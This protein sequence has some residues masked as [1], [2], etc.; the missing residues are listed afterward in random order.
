MSV[1]SN[2]SRIPYTANGVTTAFPYPYKFYNATHLIVIKTDALGNNTTYILN[3]D[4]TVTGAGSPSGGTVTFAVAPV[5]GLTITIYRKL[6]LTQLNNYVNDDDLRADVL[7]T[8]LD[9]AAMRDQQIADDISRAISYPQSEVIGTSNTLPIASVRAGKLFGFDGSGLPIVSNSN[10][11]DIDQILPTVQAA[12][13]LA[14][15]SAA[16]AAASAS[17]SYDSNQYAVASGTNTYTATLTPA[18]PSYSTGMQVELLFSNSNTGAATINLNILGAKTIQKNGSML[19][20]GEIAANQTLQLVYDGTNFQMVNSLVVIPRADIASA[21][22]TD[23]NSSSNYIR[24]TGTTTIT[25]FGSTVPTGT[26]K[27][28][29]FAGALTLTY[30]ATSM[31]LPGSA[32]I[33]TVA[34]D[35]VTVVHEG[36][37]NW[38]TTN[39]ARTSASPLNGGGS[40]A[41]GRNI[42]SR[43]NS[44][45]PNTKLDITTDE[46]VLQA[47]SFDKFTVRSV[48]VTADCTTTGANGLDTGSLATTTWYYGWVIAKIDGTIA[49]LVST[50]NSSPTM[51]S[52][53]TYKALVSAVRTDGASHFIKFRQFGNAVYYEARQLA[54]NVGSST[55]E[56]TVNVSSFIPPNALSFQIGALFTAT[57]GS[58]SG[59]DTCTLRY[60]SG[61]DFYAL[62]AYT[63]A[64]SLS[65]PDT[66]FL[67]MPNV[68]Q[69]FFYIIAGGFGS[70]NASVWVAGFKL[71][72]GGE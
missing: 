62:S 3:S 37:G 5:T 59:T 69:Q 47:T 25:S 51:P 19:T 14:V 4:Y 18:P 43:T 65:Q 41:S 22:T 29:L 20:G 8:D 32:N 54:L 40:I 70:P 36:S 48:S 55:T 33:T 58:G 60:I 66:A 50:S 63:I 39:Y 28:I 49:A 13:A 56:A 67:E 27:N 31:I 2:Q 72:L 1:N 64:G 68:S 12:A 61:S 23:L 38:R 17:L 11:T 71:P 30:N 45:T 10:L 52:G 21:S 6:P 34:G 44:V 35:T 15:A 7:E 57:A 53:Y 24:I 26:I 46:I 9:Y 16:A 42:A